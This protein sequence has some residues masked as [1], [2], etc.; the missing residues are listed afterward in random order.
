RRGYGKYMNGK[1][2]VSESIKTITITGSGSGYTAKPNVIISGDGVRAKAEAIVSGGQV[3]SIRILN[4]GIKF[5]SVPTIT[6]TGGGGSGAAAVATLT[7]RADADLSPDDV[8]STGKFHTA[9][10][11]ERSRELGF[12][13]LRKSDLVR[14]GK[15]IENMDI[16]KAQIN[17]APDYSNQKNAK[18]A[19]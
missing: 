17:V 11:K 12:E 5:S 2:S 14:W 7:T 19:Y 9:I 3:Q 1:S 16:V 4:G 18:I 6:I 13:L 8:S 15:F 10:M